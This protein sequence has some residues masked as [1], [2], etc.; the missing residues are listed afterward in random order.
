[1]ETAKQIELPD[2]IE[3]Q[4]VGK[5]YDRLIIQC[6]KKAKRNGT[7]VEHEMKV[8]SD[9]LLSEPIADIWE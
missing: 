8:L 5:Y 1:M 9:R 4:K 2:L 7:T 3:W 6:R